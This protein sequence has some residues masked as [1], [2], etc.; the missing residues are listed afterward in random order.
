MVRGPESFELIPAPAPS[1][2]AHL[3]QVPQGL[4]STAAVARSSGANGLSL[5]D[6]SS[7]PTQDAP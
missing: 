4:C 6:K 5:P 1:A 7:V 2:Y 3:C